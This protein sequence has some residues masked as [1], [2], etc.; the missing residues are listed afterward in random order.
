M[1]RAVARGAVLA[2]ALAAAPLTLSGCE[3]TAEK[4]AQ[5]ERAAKRVA[6]VAQ[7]GL[8]IAHA[9]AYVKV[10]RSEI[11]RGSRETAVVLTLR[12]D[13]AKALAEVPIAI[14]MKNASGASV[15]SNATPGLAKTLT[16]IALLAP[17]ATATWIND[18][19]QASGAVS[20]DAEIGEGKPVEGAPP[21]L[22]VQEAQLAEGSA[23]GVLANDSSMAQSELV[24]Y[25]VARR[26]GR[27][28]AAGRAVLASVAA[29]ASTPFQ[30][31]FVGDP[32]GAQLTLSAPP[33]SVG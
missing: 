19:I 6:H 29:G 24:I 23:E 16:S 11:V 30:V 26:D 13:S 32:A 4:S 5:L 27:A 28:V 22:A 18:Q 7:T 3:T 8:T 14:S 12:N 33:T 15:Y 25:A 1:R 10:L 31:F 17:H 9:S 2:L 20:V 21:R